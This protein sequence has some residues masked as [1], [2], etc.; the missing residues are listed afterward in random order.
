MRNIFGYDLPPGCRLSDIPGHSD[1]E[2]AWECIEEEFYNKNKFNPNEL[3]L[4][5]PLDE[6]V[7]SI[8]MKAIVY[9]MELGKNEQRMIEAE[10][11]YYEEE[12]YRRENRGC[13]N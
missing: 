2:Y 8:V 10:N 1:E 7:A 3:K 5:D 13:N 4:V 9:G 12:N 6:S 11:L